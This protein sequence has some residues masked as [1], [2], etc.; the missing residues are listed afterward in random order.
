MLPSFSIRL[1]NVL[2]RA[3]I[4]FSSGEDGWRVRLD[5]LAPG[6]KRLLPNMI[7]ATSGRIRMKTPDRRKRCTQPQGRVEMSCCHQRQRV[8]RAD[9]PS[10][11]SILHYQICKFP[12]ETSM[13]V[14]ARHIGQL[15]LRLDA[16]HLY[17]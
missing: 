16:T 17:F 11:R 9:Y 14:D 6:E 4:R 8:R 7:G 1:A 3:F 15:P 12:Q 13:L 2:I 5:P 10:G